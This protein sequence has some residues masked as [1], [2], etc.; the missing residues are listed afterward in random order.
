MENIFLLYAHVRFCAGPPPLQPMMRTY[1]FCQ[2][3]PSIT[4][5]LIMLL[6]PFLKKLSY[7]KTIENNRRNIAS[8]FKSFRINIQKDLTKL[9]NGLLDLLFYW[10]PITSIFHVADIGFLSWM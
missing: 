3:A 4:T 10:V 5:L 6:N 1:F 8:C 7:R 9:L 2:P